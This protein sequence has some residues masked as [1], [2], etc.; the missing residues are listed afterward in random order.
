[1]I[2]IK[3]LVNNFDTV[4]PLLLSRSGVTKEMLDNAVSLYQQ[5]NS[6][7]REIQDIQT[8][9]NSSGKPRSDEDRNA[10]KELSSKKKHL[11]LTL[12]PIEEDLENLLLSIPNIPS[13]NNDEFIRLL[14]RAFFNQN[15]PKERLQHRWTNPIAADEARKLGYPEE[16][17]KDFIGKEPVYLKP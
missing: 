13:S 8:K 9:L 7:E 12:K 16:C 1:M 5:K 3:N 11:E 2:D 10:L 14:V 15:T 17:W 4:A 6:L